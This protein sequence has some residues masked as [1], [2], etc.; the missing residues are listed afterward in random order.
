MWE[1][2]FSEK[3]YV[4]PKSFIN[5]TAW[6]KCVELWYLETEEKYS[7]GNKYNIAGQIF[8]MIS[9]FKSAIDSFKQALSIAREIGDKQKEGIWLGSLGNAYQNLGDYQ[10]AIDN[11]EQA[12]SI[13]R[14]IGDKVNEGGWLGSLGG[15]YQNLGD[16]QKAIDNYEQAVM[17]RICDRWAI[18][19]LAAAR[20]SR[21]PPTFSK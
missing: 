21:T 6:Q 1:F 11:Y 18:S 9:E 20:S 13:A 14:E 4:S 16:Y 19:W 17:R 7:K 8:L 5:R 10:K 2:C 3:E 12:L 15:A